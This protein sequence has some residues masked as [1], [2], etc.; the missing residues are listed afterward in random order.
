[1]NS[2]PCTFGQNHRNNIWR[3]PKHRDKKCETAKRFYPM[4]NIFTHRSIECINQQTSK[5]HREK[6]LQLIIQRHNEKGVDPKKQQESSGRKLPPPDHGENN[7]HCNDR[8][9]NNTDNAKR[10]GKLVIPA[11]GSHSHP[12][13]K[14][15]K[16]GRASC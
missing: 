2:P 11:I 7:T 12:C 4:H 13:V 3:P 15:W 9:H 10:L 1:M 8:L 6:E 5:K 16:I 14:I